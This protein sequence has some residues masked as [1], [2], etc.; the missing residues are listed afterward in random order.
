MELTI[1]WQRVLDEA[2]A[3]AVQEGQAARPANTRAQYERRIQEFQVA[4]SS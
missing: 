4:T 1:P 2:S 3:R